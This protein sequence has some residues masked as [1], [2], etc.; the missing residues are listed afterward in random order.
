MIGLKIRFG[1]VNYNI[2][3]KQKESQSWVKTCQ[4]LW[5]REEKEIRGHG[6]NMQQQQ[7]KSKFWFS[8]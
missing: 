3:T 2:T 4:S 5:G 6:F 7:Q 1:S 8:S